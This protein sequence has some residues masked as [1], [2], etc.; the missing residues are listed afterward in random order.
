MS[1]KGCVRLSAGALGLMAVLCGAD[2]AQAADGSLRRIGARIDIDDAN[3]P[4]LWA[5]GA[6]VK[7]KGRSSG[8]VLLVGAN[9]ALD[10]E[11][12]DNV[13]VA[14]ANAGVGGKILGD[15]SVYGSQV[16]IGSNVQGALTGMGSRLTVTSDSRIGGET[17]LSGGEVTFAGAASGPV[18]IEATN[19]EISGE[20][21]GP[22]R[23]EAT[24]VHFTDSARI[25]A[26][27]EIYTVADPVI[28]KGAKILGKVNRLSL[29]R[30]SVERL[31][32]ASGPMAGI[33]PML[34]LLGSSL[35]AGLM[36]LWLG[37]GGVEGAIDELIDSPAASGGWGLAALVGLPIAVVLLCLTVI[38]APIGALALLALPL[39]LL[40][41]YA[42]AG[43]GLGEWFFNRLGE[44]RSAGMRALHLLVG[45]F[46]L[47]LIG[48]IPWAG[49]CIL[50]IAAIC[51]FGA[52]LRML[53]DRLR[54][55]AT[56]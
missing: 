48:L 16:V 32:A 4:G 33:L 11:V 55:R 22:L 45:L 52:L 36:F 3:L 47:G 6:D 24:R 12:S 46:A 26:D 25:D 54:P 41:G 23:I 34:Y 51:G 14:G 50:A 28:D 37:R 35:M 38:G 19:V 15:L 21:K 13:Y 18:K 29:P 40:L 42:C 20:V 7:V 49:P 39:F 2:A 53:N 43:L 17:T 56:V 31:Q 9:V 30:F 8:R 1:R 5:W 27:A 10:A 44:P